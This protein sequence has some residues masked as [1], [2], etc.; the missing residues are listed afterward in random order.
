[1]FATAVAAQSES[2]PSAR[3]TRKRPRRRIP[4]KPTIFALRG[5]QSPDAAVLFGDTHCTRRLRWTPARSAPAWP[6]GR[7]P[8]RQGRGGRRFQRAAREAVAAARFPGG[9]RP[10]R[11]HGL[12]PAAAGGDPSLLADPQGR[13]WYDLIN[14]GKGAQA[15][16]EIITSFS[17][18]KIP[19]G[20]SRPGHAR[21]SQRL[22]RDHRGGGRGQR[23]RPLHR[24]H[25]LRVDLEHR[26]QQPA[27]QRHLPRR[28]REG[29]PGRAATPRSRR[30]AATTRATCGSGWPIYEEKTG[31]EVLAHRAQRQ[32]EQR[33]HVPDRR[34][35][36]RQA[37]RPRV[38]R[39]PRALGAALRGDADQGRR[40]DP[41]VP[42][43]QRRV[44]RLRAL[45]QG[46][47]RPQR[48]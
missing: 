37:D 47:P 16:I 7:L 9:G 41:S 42:L 19:K 14:S 15:A 22:A 44:R 17:Q 25:R 30:S 45:G 2:R 23:A 35:V 4:A 34:V 18:G 32:P 39:E 20:L 31:G 26:R 28:R 12:L 5:P 46:Q 13:K 10:L 40:R 24:L 38:C 27:P 48:S 8:L 11:R 33:P 43:A 36:H 21:L 29:Q 3:S 1:M 6:E